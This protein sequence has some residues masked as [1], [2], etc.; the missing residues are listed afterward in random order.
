MLNFR[1]YLIE[2]A[3]KDAAGKPLKHLRHVEDNVIYDGDEGVARA[4]RH[5]NAVHNMLLGRHAGVHVSTKWD[6]A[7]S[8]VFGKDPASG[9]FFVATK[10]AFNANPK[11]NF[12]DE[13]IERNHGHA[14]GLVEKLKASLRHLPSIMPREGGVFQGD[15]IHTTGDAKT[16]NGMTSVTPNTL[17]MSAPADSPEGQNMQKPL[18]IVIHTKY[19]GRGGLGN[20]SAGPLDDKT[21]GKFAED[22]NVNNIDPSMHVNP[23]NYTPAEQQQYLAHMEAARKTYA[24]MA[25][26]AMEALQGHGQLLEGHVN[27]QIRKGG[28]PSVQGYMDYLNAK[29]EKDVGKLKSQPTIDRRN[30]AHADMMQHITENQDHF[31]KALELHNHMQNA[32]NVLVSVMEKNNPYAHSVGGVPTGPEGAVVAD[33]NGDMSKMNNRQEFNRLNFL[34][35]AFQKNAAQAAENPE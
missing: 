8:L 32:K 22:P 2:A 10:S 34:K 6:G 27:D 19:K 4:D 23:A 21:R 25:P 31:Q 11:L 15:L 14:P 17:T 9:R 33:N 29:H 3:E 18:G 13:D 12:T 7:P 35:G 5:L 1:E 30:Q 28:A 20:M 24:K 16:E 26:E